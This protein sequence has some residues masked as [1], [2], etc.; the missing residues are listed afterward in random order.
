MAV[1]RLS[2]PQGFSGLL[3]YVGLHH[4]VC[5]PPT[6]LGHPSLSLSCLPGCPLSCPPLSYCIPPV[7]IPQPLFTPSSPLFSLTLAFRVFFYPIPS[8]TGPFSRPYRSPF[9]F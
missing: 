6:N 4:L 8:F 5:S 1:P 3:G 9:P 7:A 2:L